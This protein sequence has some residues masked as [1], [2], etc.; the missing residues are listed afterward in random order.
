MMGRE[1]RMVPPNWEHPKNDAGDDTPLMDGLCKAL[2]GWRREKAMWD[3]GYREGWGKDEPAWVPIEEKYAGSFED[4]TGGEPDPDDYMPDWAPEFRT[5]FQMYEDTSEGTPISP[6]EETP[7]A[8]ARWLAD[9]NASAFG[10][11]TATYEQW[12]TM[13]NRGWAPGAMLTV[14]NDGS[15]TMKSGVAAMADMDPT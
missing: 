6:V 8:L 2:S 12:L 5:H 10:G 14:N 4:W 13:A 7:E 1:V 9:N 15:G 3:L 11:M